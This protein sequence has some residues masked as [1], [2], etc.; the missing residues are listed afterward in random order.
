[1]WIFE[2]VKNQ[3]KQAKSKKA[4]KNTDES[5]KCKAM[6]VLPYVSGVTEKISRV[7]MSYNVAVVSKPHT[8][9]RNLPVHSIDKRDDHNTRDAFILSPMYAL[10]S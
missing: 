1:M 9:L 6:V 7:M 5:N 3:M 2:K 4:T 10:Q 8:T